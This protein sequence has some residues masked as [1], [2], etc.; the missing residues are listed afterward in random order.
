MSEDGWKAFIAADSLDDWVVLHGG[1][2]A[3]FALGS[4]VE[5]AH[6]A[7]AI[8]A[9]PMVAGTDTLISVSD[10]GT[11]VRLTR[12]VWQL[13]THHIAV[14]QAVSKLAKDHGAKAEPHRVQEVQLAIAAKADQMCLP[15]WKAIL[16]YADMADDNAVD[17]L[18]HS[19][20]IW[21]QQLAAEKGLRHAMH[22]DVSVSRHQLDARLK[23][24]I[25]AGGTIV[26]DRH[27][28]SH[29]TL[30]DPAGNRVCLCAWPDGSALTS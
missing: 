12:D 15:F 1:A 7:G 2:T 9:L 29:W 22:I 4:L 16:G 11:S 21:M 18:G 30:A 17:A 25:A 23:A 3:F 20:T 8:A 6:F 19:S 28:P 24:A 14:A 10:A 5:A 13:E 27:A 26:D